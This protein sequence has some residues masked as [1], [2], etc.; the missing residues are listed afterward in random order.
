MNYI[1]SYI[2]ITL[3]IVLVYMYNNHINT[4]SMYRYEV[5]YDINEVAYTNNSVDVHN[6][7]CTTEGNICGNFRVYHNP[8]FK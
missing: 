5:V 2:L 4:I 8:F 3:F 6:C 1:F 7:I